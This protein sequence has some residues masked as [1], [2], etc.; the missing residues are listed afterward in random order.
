MVL[1]DDD[2]PLGDRETWG[3]VAQKDD[4]LSSDWGP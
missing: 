2:G 4:G 3:S 1:F